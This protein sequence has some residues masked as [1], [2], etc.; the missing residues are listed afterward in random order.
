MRLL[1]ALTRDPNLIHLEG[2]HPVNQGPMVMSWLME[3]AR[4]EGCDLASF[5]I[6]FVAEIRGGDVVD[7]TVVDRRHGSRGIDLV[8]EARVGETLVA[9]AMA[10]ARP[11]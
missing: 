1:S 7:C 11:S 3:A 5:R 4:R 6:R 9:T 2:E 8:L 10:E